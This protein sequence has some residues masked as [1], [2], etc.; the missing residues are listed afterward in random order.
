VAEHTPWG[1]IAGGVG[2]GVLLLVAF[3]WWRR[4]RP[5][6][7]SAEQRALRELE[8]V[9][10][11][12][13]PEQGKTG[14]F[15][16]LLANVVRR[17]LEKKFQLPA[18]RRTT[19][20]FLGSLASSDKLSTERRD[21]LRDFLPRCDLAKFAGADVGAKECLAL[22]EKVRG[23]VQVDGRDSAAPRQNK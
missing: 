17:Y 19:R 13:L 8:R 16:W 10:A 2:L 3:I 7:T 15:H 14:R 9:L 6:S 4:R 21:F 5:A 18:R 20:E 11:L 1:A 22:A 12:R 23:F